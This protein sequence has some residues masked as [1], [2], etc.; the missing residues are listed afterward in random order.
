MNYDYYERVFRFYDIGIVKLGYTYKGIHFFEAP[1]II[2]SKRGRRKSKGLGVFS[3]L[4]GGTLLNHCT[5]SMFSPQPYS[6]LY[7]WGWYDLKKKEVIV[8][9][10]E[11]H[12]TYDFTGF[13]DKPY[14]PFT[15]TAPY[16]Q[17]QLFIKP[18]EYK[19]TFSG[20][21]DFPMQFWF[22]PMIGRY[23]LPLAGCDRNEYEYFSKE[24]SV[25]E[26]WGNFDFPVVHFLAFDS[27]KEPDGERRYKPEPFQR[28]MLDLVFILYEQ[29]IDWEWEMENF[30]GKPREFA[31]KY[32]RIDIE[33]STIPRSIQDF[34]YKEVLNRERLQILGNMYDDSIS[35]LPNVKY[36]SEGPQK[37]VRYRVFSDFIRNEKLSEVFYQNDPFF[38]LA[39]QRL[40]LLEHNTIGSGTSF[41]PPLKEEISAMWAISRR[42]EEEFS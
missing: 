5:R 1:L 28:A 16:E 21:L 24:S 22:L 19:P 18:Y 9:P 37:E 14:V 38:A 42:L 36:I 13:D 33:F 29:V 8:E 34:L 32:P 27:F 12:Y 15:L 39:T 41:L 35:D 11:K 31:E 17:S 2:Y 20:H 30:E 4:N 10:F 26:K 3:S 23:A 7:D 40:F 25:M 6:I